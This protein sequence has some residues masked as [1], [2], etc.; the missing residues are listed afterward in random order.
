MQV[1]TVSAAKWGIQNAVFNLIKQSTGPE[2]EHTYLTLPIHAIPEDI[3]RIEILRNR[4]LNILDSNRLLYSLYAIHFFWLLAYRYINENIDKYDVVWLH[5]PMLLVFLPEKA[6]KKTVITIHGS[7][8]LSD[9]ESHKFPT[10][11]YYR[12][13]RFVQ[14]RGI[15]NRTDIKYTAVNEDIADELRELNIP[16]E[17]IFLIGNGV[18]ID[19]F[20]PNTMPRKSIERNTQDAVTLVS[21]ARFIELKRPLHLLEAF[22]ETKEKTK[23][24]LHLILVGEGPLQEQAKQLARNRGITDSVTFLGVVDYSDMP[25]IYTAGDI[26]V[27]SSESEGEPLVLYEAMASGL[28]SIVSNIPSCNFVSDEDCGIVVD[29]GDVDTA[30]DDIAEF[31]SNNSQEYGQ[32]AREYAKQHLTWSARVKEYHEIFYMLT[33][34]TGR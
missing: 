30:S 5:S 21:V 16:S 11:I 19:Q 14:R 1:L 31:F 18:D 25:E 15:R 34:G 13:L 12:L 20:D 33:N 23:S 9:I 17:N 24:E 6:E 8:M 29:F 10:N 28:P 27:L 32:N 7:L 4:L 26:F 22:A 3:K 2:I